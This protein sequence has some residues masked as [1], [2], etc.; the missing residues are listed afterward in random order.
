MI[1]L[2]RKRKN[3][4]MDKIDSIIRRASKMTGGELKEIHDLYINSCKQIVN[5]YCTEAILSIVDC[6]RAIELFN[7]EPVPYSNGWCH[8]MLGTFFIH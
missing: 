4:D 2:G 8:M 7:L 3:A 6:P 1:M 5:F